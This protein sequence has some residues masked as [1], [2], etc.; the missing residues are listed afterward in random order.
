M[1]R[2]KKVT[3]VLLSALLVSSC[4]APC[5]FAASKTKVGKINLTIDTDIRSGGSGGEVEVTPTGD[6]SEE[7][8]VGKEC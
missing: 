5:T 4:M 7:R 1:I 3:A 8:R 2:L 6:R